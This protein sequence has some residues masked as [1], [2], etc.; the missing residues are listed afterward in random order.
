MKATDE[1]SLLTVNLD[2]LKDTNEPMTSDAKG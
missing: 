2:Q 1:K